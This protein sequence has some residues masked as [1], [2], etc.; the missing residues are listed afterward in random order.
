MCVIVQGLY[1][2]EVRLLGYENPTQRCLSNG[3]QR[4]SCCD[5]FNRQDRC[6][7]GDREC[8]SYFIYCLRPFQTQGSQEGGCSNSDRAERSAVNVDDGMID[9]SQTE[10]LG[11]NNPFQLQGL[12]DDYRVSYLTLVNSECI[13]Y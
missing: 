4:L 12:T 13:E 3:G 10:V 6:T 2:V 11:L 8:D 5:D 7:D 1:Q 9:F